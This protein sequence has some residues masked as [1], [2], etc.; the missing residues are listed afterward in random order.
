MDL[1]EDIKIDGYANE[2]T[3]C[4]INIFNNA[5]DALIE[6]K[7]EKRFIFIYAYRKEDKVVIKINDNAKGI[8]ED[9]MPR[10]FEP[11]FTTKHQ[12]QG[13]GLGLHMIYNLIINGMGGSI[14]AKNINFK[15]ND[16]EYFGAEF[17]IIL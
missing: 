1:H 3:Q 17:K 14:T 15:Y 16:I 6:N 12:S 13:T 8:D 5:K 7:I 4:F 10:I 11:Y 9:I 2:L